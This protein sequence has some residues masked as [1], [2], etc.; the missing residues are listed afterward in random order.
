MM[1]Y[2]HSQKDP[3]SGVRRGSKSLQVHTQGVWDKACQALYPHTRFEQMSPAD[4]A[5]VLEQVCRLHDLGKATPFFQDYLLGQPVD[6]EKKT[7][8]RLGAHVAFQALV[9]APEGALKASLAYLT[10]LFHHQNL[11]TPGTDRL[12]DEPDHVLSLVDAQWQALPDLA[13]LAKV[14][15]TSLPDG[16]PK[17]RAIRRPINAL[18][19]RGNLKV[20]HYFL[21]NYLFSLLIEADKLDA[22]DTPVHVRQPLPAV[23]VAQY[24]AGFAPKVSPLVRLREEMRAEVNRQLDA[25][26]ILDKR[27]MLLT[28][29]TGLGKTLTALGAALK[30]RE[31]IF[32]RE[33]RQAQIITALPFINIIEQTLQVYQE[34]LG[35]EQVRNPNIQLLAH[36]QYADVM[37]EPEKADTE[38]WEAKG[39]PQK[40]MQLDTWQADVVIT[41]FVQLLQ[42][43]ISNR[44]KLLKKFHHLAGAIVIMDEVQSIRLEQVPLVGAML[45]Y[46]AK[47]LDTRLIL[48]TATQPLI[49]ELADAH[50]LRSRGESAVETVFP[51]IVKPE[52]YFHLFERTQLVPYLEEVLDMEAFLALFEEKWQSDQSCLIVCNKVLRSLEV[53]AALQEWLEDK[54]YRNAIHYLSTNVVPA[55][56]L[57][58]I[59]AIKAELKAVR[60]STIG[61]A[62]PPILVA[63]Q[64]VEAGVDLDFDMGFRD[65]GPV[66]SIIQVAGRINRENRE[67]SKLSPL[68]LIDWGD[69]A[70]IYG[71]P[72]YHQAKAAL[73]REPIPEPAYYELV[74]RYF[75]GATAQGAYDT[76]LAMFHAVEGL[77]YSENTLVSDGRTIAD[78]AVIEQ[79]KWATQVYVECDE[80]AIG[81]RLAFLAIQDAKGEAKQ[82]A[83]RQFEAHFKRCFH[84]HIITVP[85]YLVSGRLDKMGEAYEDLDLY[86]LPYDQAQYWYRADTGMIRKTPPETDVHKTLTF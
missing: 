59:E 37:G 30:L 75:I 56:R 74:Q 15:D 40:M 28:A 2:S 49:F 24:L 71:P 64:V 39:Y 35:P 45:Y 51:L 8:A 77:A 70:D 22:S 25:P 42:T 36:Y 12:F 52:R 43:L 20:E 23:A 11:Q 81:A 68:Y 79:A 62:H 9:N 4:L 14:L 7:H 38:D 3:A 44:N 60:Q 17:D 69:G 76:S 73:G 86:Y 72:A 26:G 31:L 67:D 65:I 55:H 18:R 63:T 10:V 41:S 48:M 5:E 84:Q 82:Q 78:F 85:R 1:L 19:K 66:D 83:K 27:L 32:L 46:L 50:I 6:W 33:N 57:G 29:P 21:L 53:F 80:E 61:N 34:V 13:S 47:F 54:G 16:L 58:R